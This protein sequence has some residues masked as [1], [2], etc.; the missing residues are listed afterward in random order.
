MMDGHKLDIC[1]A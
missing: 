1:S